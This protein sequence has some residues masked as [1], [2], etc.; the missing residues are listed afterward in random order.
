[1]RLFVLFG[2][3][4]SYHLSFSKDQPLLQALGL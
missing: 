1:V 3:L 2:F 4:Q